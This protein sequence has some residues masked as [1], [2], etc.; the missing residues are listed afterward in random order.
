MGAGAIVTRV[1]F[2]WELTVLARHF[3]YGQ[4]LDAPI[5]IDYR[6]H[7]TSSPRAVFQVLWDT[8]TNFYRLRTLPWYAGAEPWGRSLVLEELPAPLGGG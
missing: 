3:G 6:S 2:D 4:I 1:A 7:S 8:L 5:Q